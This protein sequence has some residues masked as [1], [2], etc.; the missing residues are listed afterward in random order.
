MGRKRPKLGGRVSWAQALRLDVDRWGPTGCPEA[1]T[2]RRGRD[3]EIDGTMFGDDGE[4]ISYTVD[5]V[6]YVIDL[7]D[8]HAKELREIFEYY[9]AHS[10]RVGGRKHHADRPANPAVRKQRR[11]ETKKVWLHRN[12]GYQQKLGDRYSP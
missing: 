6:E 8:E 5:G 10:T 9:T 11:G 4:S 3:R 7:K 2:F 12:S 1:T